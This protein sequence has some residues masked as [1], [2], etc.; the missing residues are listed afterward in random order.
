MFEA[1]TI[2]VL[3]LLVTAWALQIWLSNHQMRRFHRRTSQ[4]RRQGTHLAVGLAGNM[5]RRK[6]YV[7]LVIDGDECV[8]AA[9]ELSGW[10]IF[11]SL[12]RR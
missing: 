9:E 7:A 12:A 5:Y 2:T 4:L 3:V 10:T 1:S 6:T 11:A 8:A